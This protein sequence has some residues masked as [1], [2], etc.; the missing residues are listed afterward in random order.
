MH[1]IVSFLPDNKRIEDQNFGRAA[2]NGQPGT[3][4]LI[5][6]KTEEGFKEDDIREVKKIRGQNEFDMITQSMKTE[7]PK[8]IFEDELFDKFCIFLD[9]I[10][11][12]N[13]LDENL[14]E[15]SY[16]KSIKERSI[17][18]KKNTEEMWGA[19]IKTIQDRRISENEDF[20]QFKKEKLKN[21]KEFKQDI[22][23]KIKN[24]KIFQNPFLNYKRF[25]TIF[26]NG[27]ELDDYSKKEY[28][29]LLTKES[30]LNF[31]LYYNYAVYNIIKVDDFKMA[32]NYYEKA[33]KNLED[34]SNLFLDKILMLN[35]MIINKDKK[36]IQKKKIPIQ[37]SFDNKKI[38]I[39]GVITMI[40]QNLSKIE[41]FWDRRN[42]KNEKKI[43]L[44]KD[45]DEYI[46]DVLKSKT[47]IKDE[48]DL[49][50]LVEFYEDFGIKYLIVLKI[51]KEIDWL[52]FFVVLFT[53]I[54]EVA[55]GVCLICSGYIN[56]GAFLLKQGINDIKKSIDYYLGKA[57]I[58]L[59]D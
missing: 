36:E 21:F 39:N 32:K 35:S 3:G 38:S 55:I 20:E 22:L 40:N 37:K 6:N 41:E 57:E 19:F 51:R 47:E 7:V 42:K 9:E 2:R 13:K 18:I 16:D 30:F 43:Y 29:S 52:S 50:E 58:N 33:K 24:K 44:V 45:T 26:Y 1:V 14:F 31:G 8:Q 11:D 4:R 28:E 25:G 15:Q 12:Q 46:K 5:L 48:E 27:Y 59:G 17:C 54:V 56:F 49:K 23:D 53:G 34:F 10:V